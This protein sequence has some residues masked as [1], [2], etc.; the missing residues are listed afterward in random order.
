LN[1]S[2]RFQPDFFS[3]RATRSFRSAALNPNNLANNQYSPPQSNSRKNTGCSGR[4]PISACMATSL[5]GRP[6]FSTADV[7]KNNPHQQF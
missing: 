5:I 2:R 6:K 7:R 3:I 4:Y 1:F